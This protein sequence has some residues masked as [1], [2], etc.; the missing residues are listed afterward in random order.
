ME[1]NISYKSI[2]LM[3]PEYLDAL[4]GTADEHI[5]LEF[6]TDEYDSWCPYFVFS[7]NP[8]EST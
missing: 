4:H 2:T 8:K 7:W 1:I 3:H 5:W 6:G